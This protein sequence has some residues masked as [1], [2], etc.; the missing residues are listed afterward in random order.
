MLDSSDFGQ[1]GDTGGRYRSQFCFFFLHFDHKLVS[2]DKFFRLY[3]VFLS[4]L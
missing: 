4:L 1:R 3:T 2:I